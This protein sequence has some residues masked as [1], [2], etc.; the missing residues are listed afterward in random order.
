[1]TVSL[2]SQRWES[3]QMDSGAEHGDLMSSLDLVRKARRGDRKALD[4]LFERYIP[5]LRRWVTGRLPRWARDLT[6][7][8]D[9]IQEAM[10]KTFRRLDKFDPKRGSGGLH[11]YLR[12]VLQHRI[13]DELR[14]AK[15]QPARAE[16]QPTVA[17][18]AASPL[19][20]TVGREAADRYEAAL[21]R[22][23]DVEREAVI[24][25]VELGFNYKDIAEALGTPSPDAARMTVV[26]A[27][28]RLSQE[29]GHGS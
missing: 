13:V 1:M 12:Q 24:A 7:T 25:R 15:R 10:L 19:Q 5:P 14:R 20:K 26:R 28:V 4:R 29:M 22:L 18:P 8:D 27:L 23:R 21:G 6:D 17:D 9:M 16:L 3:R 2:A 11:A